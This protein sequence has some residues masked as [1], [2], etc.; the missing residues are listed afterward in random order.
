[1]ANTSSARKAAR[2]AI[3][4]T[5]VNKSRRSLY[6]TAV[7]KVEEAIAAPPGLEQAATRAI[8][9][10]GIDY[11]QLDD[12]DFGATQVRAEPELWNLELVGVD[13][14]SRLY[15]IQW[16]RAQPVT[17]YLPTREDRNGP[18]RNKP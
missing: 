17:R 10:L 6:R 8:K 7:R 5:E 16:P 1:M 13:G 11:L 3:R 9:D 2:Q 14:A 18:N 15:R 12:A 4:R